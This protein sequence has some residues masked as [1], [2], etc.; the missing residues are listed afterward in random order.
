ML[1]KV[2]YTVS[3]GNRD[4]SV[5]QGYLAKSDIE[6]L[7]NGVPADFTWLTST[8]IRLTN[9]PTNGHLVRINRLTPL[10]NFGVDFVDGSNITE[11][12]LD[13]AYRQNFFAAQETSDRLDF[14][15]EWIQ[16]QVISGQ[17]LPPVY[18]DNSF[19]I[20]YSNT[21]QVKTLAQAKEILGL[22]STSAYTTIPNPAGDKAV[23]YTDGSENTFSLL[24]IESLATELKLGTMAVLTAE[25]FPILS[26][27]PGTSVG[28]VV[29][30]VNIST[31]PLVNT[32]ALPALNASQLTNVPKKLHLVATEETAYNV[33]A[34]QYTST[35]T[36]VPRTLTT[37]KRNEITGASLS[38]GKI[39]LPK[40]KYMVRV[41]TRMRVNAAT[42]IAVV[43]DGDGNEVLKGRPVYGG[44]DDQNLYVYGYVDFDTDTAS[45]RKIEVRVAASA[46]YANNDALGAAHGQS[47]WGNNVHTL[48]EI[49]WLPTA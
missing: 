34:G 11:A 1:S 25:D 9:T 32:P 10:T 41:T 6:V 49:E 39:V 29:Q 30:L 8:T 14:W 23:V 17:D 31:N 19:L 46:N 18:N 38:S 21:W 40:G 35:P 36:L 44:G 4:Y 24:T 15:E 33:A 7:V 48:V 3:G 28:N 5:P 20:S 22:S 42:A 16:N 27:S 43:F 12:D 37:I 45:T 13:K 26:T 47:T 2:T